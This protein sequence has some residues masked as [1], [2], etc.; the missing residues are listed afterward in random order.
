MAVERATPVRG[1][2]DMKP[3][4]RLERRFPLLFGLLGACVLGLLVANW[5]AYQELREAEA[6][7]SHTHE[8]LLE[9]AELERAV[10]PLGGHLLCAVLGASPGAPQT[11][12]D[13]A[14]ILQRLRVR[15]ADNA[16]QLRTLD[17]L[18]PLLEALARGY[19]RPIDEACR[20]PG[21]MP[22]TRV[23][24]LSA[25]GVVH[26]DRILGYIALMRG[27]EQRLLEQRQAQLEARGDVLRRRFGL[28]VLAT[29][30]L[31]ALAPFGMRGVTGRLAEAYRRLR[32]EAIERGMAREQQRESQ[33]R[34]EMVLE[35]VSEAVIGLDDRLRVQWLN[36]AGEAM[37]GRTRASL[38]GQPLAH[39]LPGIDE[40]LERPGVT[41]PDFD[42]TDAK[43]PEPWLTVRRAVEGRRPDGVHFIAEAV[44]VHG[45]VNGD[46]L[47][48]CVCR[49]LVERA[50]RAA[51]RPRRVAADAP[52]DA[53]VDVPLDVA[54]DVPLDVRL[55]DAP[56][57]AGPDRAPPA[58]GGADDRTARETAEDP[59]A[60]GRRAR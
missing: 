41:P 16:A 51:G 12:P 14:P 45:R 57:V 53:P 4:G 20:G 19:A 46:L 27:V 23:L 18:P 24:D 28:L 47:G 33:R 22:V 56:R 59:A 34:L 2:R 10:Q 60:D 5:R 48:V 9:I 7:R 15:V 8:V 50:A 31:A 32:H 29:A 39:L 42:D 1:R 55:D 17:E 36:P 6:W 40:D 43:P 30:A 37:F 21:R 52:V 25:I 13:P 11:L 38:R 35:H 54:V 26:R 3:P 49:P 58:A 44:L